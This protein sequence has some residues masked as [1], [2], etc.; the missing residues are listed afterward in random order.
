MRRREPISLDITSLIDIIFIVII[1]FIVTSSFKKEHFALNI[2]LPS[3]TAKEIKID[4]KQL[5]IEVSKEKLAYM[6]KKITFLE[7]QKKLELIKNHKLPVVVKIDKT[8]PYKR[9][10]EVLDI[11]Q[12]NDLNNL[13]LVTSDK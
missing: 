8:V 5:T 2:T 13:A 11:L 1:F 10:V 9:V 6:G 3:A 4:T 12:L 7:L